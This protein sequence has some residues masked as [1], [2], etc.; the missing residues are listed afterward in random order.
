MKKL[1]TTLLITLISL[2]TYATHLMG[3]QIVATNIGGYDYEIKLTAYRDTI[4]IP[5]ATT[6][7]FEISMDSAGVN[8]PIYFLTIPG[9]SM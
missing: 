1:L 7:M 5:M 3:G 4:G 2:S 6:A 9:D 8:L